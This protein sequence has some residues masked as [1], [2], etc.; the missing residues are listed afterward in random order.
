MT[1]DPIVSASAEAAHNGIELSFA[2]P[3]YNEEA[4]VVA[5]YEAVKAEAELHVASY[6]IIFIDN[7]STDATRTLLREICDRDPNVRAI[8]NNRNYGQMRSPTY[9]LY[10]AEGA[11]VIAMCCDFQDPPA[12][13]GEMVRQWRA[14]AQIVLG[15]R[16]SEKASPFL[17]LARMGGYAF[18]RKFA[19][20][21]VIPGATGFGLYDR[22][23]VDMFASWN[24]P[25]P[26][27]RGMAVESGYRLAVLPFDR[28]ERAGGK[29]S[30]NF[31]TLLNFALSGL[32]GSAKSLLRLPLVLS[33]FLGLFTLGLTLVTILRL[34]FIGYSPLM[35]G[36]TVI[37]AMFSV[38]L[39]F[40]GLIGDQLRLLVERSRNLP[41]VIEAER[42]NFPAGRTLPAARTV[43]RAHMEG[44]A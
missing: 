6:E 36:I 4:N 24:E 27:V 5:M 16:K 37:A 14:G 13:I 40:I 21:A 28:P 20:H 10:Q 32:A 41:L 43:N 44:R 26:F 38:L 42:L 2:I 29:T 30:N 11:A 33:I 3:C 35:I 19:D 8:F 23:V 17:G 15:Q 9:A 34:I 7:M 39:L 31:W 22:E 12:L 1:E 18:L 25:E